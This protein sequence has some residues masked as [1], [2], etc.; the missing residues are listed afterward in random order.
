MAVV[1]IDGPE[2]DRTRRRRSRNAGDRDDAALVTAE[3]P[4][5]SDADLAPPFPDEP[6]G[7]VSPTEAETAKTAATAETAK[8]TEI[9]GPAETV[10]REAGVVRPAVEAP[11]RVI[12][13]GDAGDRATPVAPDGSIGPVVGV[14]SRA[15]LPTVTPGPAVIKAS[16]PLV[17]DGGGIVPVPASTRPAPGPIDERGSDDP[18]GIGF[19]PTSVSWGEADATFA[20]PGTGAPRAEPRV[21]LIGD[22]DAN[23][24]EV[25]IDPRIKARRT[26][27]KR[28]AGLRRLRAGVL[29]VAA[30]A[31]VFGGGT[32]LRSYVLV[33]R[34]VFVTG[35]SSTPADTIQSAVNSV[36][37]RS[38]VD[39]SLVD[40]RKQ[41]E[42]SPWVKSVDVTRD[43]PSTIR[44]D[45]LERRPVAYFRGSDDH[46]Y[47]VDDAGLV[48]VLTDG[49]PVGLMEVTGNL[50][51]VAP[52]QPAAD[53]VRAGAVVA[54]ALP[55]PLRP[56]VAAIDSKATGVALRMAGTK[57]QILLGGT[58][59]LATKL[60]TVLA[61]QGTC[62]PG[63]YDTLDVR[64]PG[65][66]AV[67]PAVGC[68]VKK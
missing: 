8:M 45:V 65:K 11:K 44:V 62:P 67:T 56:L 59:D 14:G 20:G 52:G 46:G 27:V 48:L 21:V 24:P 53:T 2:H 41:F 31:L 34:K 54:N 4:L 57:G 7:P 22:V 5:V 55:A 6:D 68:K 61:F 28:S 30:L 9:A 63:S 66:P 38:M 16:G 12:V 19:D 49:A 60:I 47:V 10:E 43:W 1:A 58:D 32:V 25:A 15:V 64:V 29:I 23:P 35:T 13:I 18:I 36:A 40:L 33:V 50:E 39:V 51:P 3:L 26:Q 42:Q 37:G 17:F